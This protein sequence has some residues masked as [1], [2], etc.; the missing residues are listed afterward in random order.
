MVESGDEGATGGGAAP[1]RRR[2]TPPVPAPPNPT[3]GSRR[4]RCSTWTRFSTGRRRSVSAASPGCSAPCVRPRAPGRPAAAG[5]L[6][7]PP[8]RARGGAHRPAPRRPPRAV[9]ARRRGARGSFSAL[10]PSLLVLAE[11]SV[12]WPLGQPG[13]VRA[14][15]P[16]LR[17]GRPVRHRPG[18]R[19]GRRG[20]SH[21]LR[22][23]R[24]RR[25]V[26]AGGRQRHRPAAAGRQPGSSVS[27]AGAI[28]SVGLSVAL[29]A[30]QPLFLAVVVVA[31]VP[32]WI[33]GQPGRPAP[34]RLLGAADRTRPPPLLPASPSSAAGRRRPRCAATAWPL[35]A[36]LARPPLRRAHRRPA[37]GR[38]RAG[39]AWGRSAS[40]SPP[41]CC[42]GPWPSSCGSSARDGR[43]SPRRWRRQARSSSLNGRLSGLVRSASQLYEASLFLEDFTDFVEDA[44]RDW[45]G[46]A[47]RRSEGSARPGR[48]RAARSST[49]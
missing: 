18:A 25:P 16:A 42:Q 27:S 44:P 29:L 49:A 33:G 34:P 1:P 22:G 17:A 3:E 9:P 31:Y 2:R 15:A 40:W 28:A 14:A 6:G 41:W 10:V 30:L 39:S 26:A 12:R 24:V 37:A 45:P 20:R 47:R 32:A 4:L 46:P 13:P 48:L 36:R 38:P 35:P 11:V 8:G 43:P 19:G 7:R 21:R 5:A 23:A